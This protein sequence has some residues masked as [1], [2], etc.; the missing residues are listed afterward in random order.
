MTPD[1]DS[2]CDSWVREQD[3]LERSLERQLLEWEDVP[4]DYGMHRDC[5]PNY[6]ED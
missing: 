4:S 1:N 3:R 6:K 2:I 5:Y